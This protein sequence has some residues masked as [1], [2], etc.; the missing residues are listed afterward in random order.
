MKICKVCNKP[1]FINQKEI[2]GYHETCL[3]KR[4]EG[5]Y[6]VYELPTGGLIKIKLNRKE[7]KKLTEVRIIRSI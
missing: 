6:V 3:K 5:Q 2:F 7:R 4:I 1:I